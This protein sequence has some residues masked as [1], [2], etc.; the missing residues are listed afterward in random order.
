ML[1]IR[2]ALVRDIDAIME[3]FCRAR[4]FMAA[5]GNPGQ[6]TGGY[7]SRELLLSEIAASHCFVC[8][9]GRGDI[10]GTF[11][12]IIGEDPTYRLIEQG[13]WLSPGPYGTVHRLASGGSERGIADSCF[14]WC[15][16]RI[17]NLR[18]D[19]HADNIPMQNAL[20]KNGFRRC[21]IIYTD[22]GSARIAYQKCVVRP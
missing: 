14:N 4:A 17:H 11:C 7:P 5:H 8:T 10:A 21:G 13:S 15:W 3:I 2:P 12:F 1:D 19:T 18:A 20:A 16:E 9:D 6:W 22:N